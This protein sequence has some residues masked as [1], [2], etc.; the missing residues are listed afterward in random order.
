MKGVISAAPIACTMLAVFVSFELL[1]LNPAFA[2]QSTVDPRGPLFARTDLINGTQIGAW[3]MDGGTAVHNSSARARVTAA[4][5][6][7]IRWQM[8]RPPCDLRPTNCQTTAQFNAAIDGIR[9]LGAEPLIGLPPIWDEQCSNGPDPWSYAWQQWEVRT[10]GSRVQL[11]EIG[12]EP[13]NYCG[14]SGQTYHDQ[15]WTNAA[16][17]KKY[18]RSLGLAIFVG[19]PAWANS[20]THS[21][22]D[23]QTWLLATRADYLAH[24]SDRDYLPDFV[25]THTYLITPSENDTQAHAQSRVDSWGVFYDSLSAWI[26]TNFAGLTDQGYPI[27]RELKLVDSEYNDT[28]ILSSAINNSQTWTDFYFRAMFAMF[29]AHGVWAANQFT[30]A[31]ENGA[32]DM[33][34]ADGSPKPEYFSFLAQT[35]AAVPGPTLTT[36]PSPP[37]ATSTPTAMPTPKHRPHR[38]ATATPQP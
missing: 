26:N 19:G 8:W 9:S 4:G 6:K 13:D 17:L 14:M 21:L 32:M 15:L 24:G 28:I 23:V 25:S 11:Y 18:G 16:P 5:V 12:N 29:R 38:R 33:L 20:Y 27:A 7:V 2:A 37:T 31:S 22:A 35:T 1:A 10:A 34:N 30:I 36:I 3:D